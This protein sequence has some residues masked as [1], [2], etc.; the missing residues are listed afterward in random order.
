MFRRDVRGML[1]ELHISNYYL[2]TEN[3]KHFFRN[4]LTKCVSQ[5]RPETFELF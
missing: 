2:I 1:L 4:V 5:K 3:R